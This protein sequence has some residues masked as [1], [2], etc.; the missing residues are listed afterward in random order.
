VSWPPRGPVPV[1]YFPAE[2]AWNVSLNARKYNKPGEDVTAKVYVADQKG[3]KTGDPLKLNYSGVDT[4]PFGIPYCIIFRPEKAGVAAGRRYVVE[5]EG[6][7]SG[8]EKKAA[9]LR[10]AVEFVTAK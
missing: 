10:Y 7:T 4:T 5:I 6:L 8:K 3:N 9:P 2:A 1:D